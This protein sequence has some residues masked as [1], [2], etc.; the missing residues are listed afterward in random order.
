[1]HKWYIL[2][3]IFLALNYVGFFVHDTFAANAPGFETEL[4]AEWFVLPTAVVTTPDGRIF[5]AEKAG[6]IHVIK[7]GAVLPTPLLTL[8]DVNN[9]GDRWLIGFTLDPNFSSNGYIYVGYTYENT[10]GIQVAWSKTSRVVRYTVSG[11]T[12]IAGSKLVILG[13]VG[14]TVGTPSCNDYPV[15]SDCIP[16]DAISHSVGALHF[17][18]DGKLYI[19]TGDG[20]SFDYAD[21]LS[22]RAQ[23]LD[24]LAGKVLRI[25][26]DGT[27]PADNPFFT[28]D[29]NANRSKIWAYGV[30]NMF[31]FNFKPG[32]NQIFWGDVGWSSWEEVNLITP[33]ANLGWP[34]NEWNGP[35]PL[36]LGCTAT[37]AVNPLYTYPHD[38]NGAGSVVG[39]VFFS[40]SYPA[41][42]ANSY[43]YGDYAQNSF[44]KMNLTAGNSIIS[45][46][47]LIDNPEGPVDITLGN[48]GKIYF[49]SIYTGNLYRLNYTL[50]NR[51]PNA[52]I[53]ANPTAGSIP[54]VV[55]FSAS[56]SSDPDND[57]LSYTWN[58]PGG[59]TASGMNTTFTFATGWVYSV[60]VTV[61]DGNGWTNT[62]S[63]DITAGNQKPTATI[64]APANGYRYTLWEPIQFQWSGIDPETWAIPSG[65]IR[66]D[67]ILHHNVHLHFLDVLT[68]SV[69]N[70]SPPDHNDT[71]VYVEVQMTVTDPAGLTDTKSINLYLNNAGSATGNLILNPSLETVTAVADNPD[72][73]IKGW[74]GNLDPVFSYPI[75]GIHG[76]KAARV[77]V[78]SYTEWDAKWS[79]SPVSVTAGKTY[80]FQNQYR[81]NVQTEFYVA[82][83]YANGTYTYAPFYA[84]PSPTMWAFLSG[85][86]T[87]PEGWINASLTHT[88]GRIG[89]LETDNYYLGESIPDNY[90]PPIGKDNSITVN[91]WTSLITL[92]NILA[93]DLVFGSGNSLLP[94][95]ID[96]NSLISEPQ[97]IKV[98]PE[99]TWTANTTNGDV[100]FA[101]IS[102]FSGT[103]TIPYSAKDQRGNST[104]ANLIVT[105]N[106]N[107]PPPTPTNLITN[108]GVEL[109]AGTTPTGWNTGWYGNNNRV[110]TY[111]STWALSGQRSIKVDITSYTDGDGKW[112]FNDIPVTSGTTYNYSQQY[113]STA[114]TYLYARFQLPGNTYQYQFLKTVPAN[115]TIIPLTLTASVIAP[116]NATSMT[117]W[118]ALSS[119]GSLTLDTFSL[120]T[121]GTNTGTAPD[122][123]PPEVTFVSPLSG[124][125]LSGNVNLTANTSDDRW[126]FSVHFMLANGTHISPDST[127]S[128][129]TYSWDTR[130]VANGTYIVY[131]HAFDTA[132]NQKMTPI[133][134]FINNTIVPPP[135]PTNLITNSG[136]EL[137][138]GTT[139]TGWNTGWYGNNN[140][141]FTYLSTWALSGQRSIKV[142]ITSYTDGDGK[143]FF[144]DIP[145]T[146]GTTYNYSQQYIS[147]AP[148]Y[149]Y[150]RFQLP[151][152]TYQYQ[153][154]KTV[155]ANNTIIPLTLTAS[156]IAPANATSMTIWNA[157][158]SI[159]SLTLD[160]FSLSTPGTNTGTAPDTVPPTVTLSTPIELGI[161][162]GSINVGATANDNIGVA[163]VEFF[164]D[165]QSI[166]TDTSTPYSINLNT[167]VYSG[168]VHS[169]TARARDTNNNTTTTGERY[170]FTNNK[171]SPP[172]TVI[173]SEW[174]ESGT[175]SGG[176]NTPNQN[177]AITP[178]TCRFGPDTN[179]KALR[180]T[181]NTYPD[182]VGLERSVSV[183]GYTGITLSFCYKWDS[184]EWTDGIDVEYTLDNGTSWRSAKTINNAGIVHMFY[185]ADDSKIAVPNSGSLIPTPV[186]LS[187]S[188]LAQY[189]IELPPDVGGN[190]F[191]KLRIR[192]HMTDGDDYVW[193]DDI[194]IM[195]TPVATAD[196]TPPTVTMA[197]PLSGSTLSGTIT[198]RATAT[199]N[200]GVAWVQF[201]LDGVN[202]GAEDTTSPYQI[203]YN[204]TLTGNGSHTF[205][206]IARDAAWNTRTSSWVV[207]I[208]TNPTTG[209]WVELVTNGGLELGTLTTPTG[210]YTG[211]YGT[212]N[213]L[214]S[215][216][217]TGALTGQKS[218][219]VDI[220]SYTSGDGKWIFNDVP[221]TVG[222]T[223]I[224]SQKY[225]STVPSSLLVRYK[226]A[227][228]TY[229]YVYLKYLP[230]AA[231]ATTTTAEFTVPANITAATVWMSLDTIWSTI[232]DDVSLKQK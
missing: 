81:S 128:P 147:T 38:S 56:G 174:F 72:D 100:T 32:T 11:D 110:F 116:A 33:G 61:N 134:V 220:T 124:S 69:V 152:N 101:P 43:V 39:G 44:I 36:G 62:K 173:F 83:W 232:I 157:L 70:F 111:L 191:F 64:I 21:P 108:S 202:I 31:R 109:S 222:N 224:Y 92:P 198:V 120:S 34:C 37:W 227:N 183:V 203:S 58:F 118:N 189:Y 175:F 158:S 122:T 130:T 60:S 127:I 138:A 210:W 215:Y 160:T 95:S 144:N 24:S 230:T 79:P 19:S 141:V 195:G 228:N 114:P 216:I 84:P 121:P 50:W 48:D 184:L 15:T 119:I 20:A 167:L 180:V 205:R 123:T 4:I 187:Q 85:S 231:V 153:F 41:E 207:V 146:S 9:F 53:S 71:D 135:T 12:V 45:Q 57:I 226:L 159:G 96:L 99:G 74:W 133:T 137:S 107:V 168:W 204:S 3:L 82:V 17:G 154:L 194:K 214:F 172:T 151:G 91:Y 164:I 223:Y 89:W 54:L 192:D 27:A 212:N 170:I 136:V 77:D 103:T 218:V 193:I 67:F 126:A 142:D 199:D 225:A 171:K 98:N 200:I 1:M 176:W 102:G 161:Y 94:A 201:Q 26:P 206:A 209:T 23:N 66:W 197:Q 47:N 87:I 93:N 166:W 78:L 190:S 7:N 106:S 8:T 150:A 149:L 182:G 221:V 49:L 140:R 76:E 139:P 86:Y 129:Y 46:E 88:V 42:F 186:S 165:G 211:G 97:S 63:I 188:G 5:V 213:R 196:T 181:G 6:V 2:G 179:T 117:I 65:S 156:V 163:S 178:G 75:T 219:K 132:G 105:I 162:S 28:G 73:W 169:L 131:A 104:S 68:G 40:N 113:I 148:T 80:N 155:P 59:S 125:T 10:P 51:Q 25:N 208:I 145:V 112:F 14:G 30:R 16:S 13:S 217:S 90:I 143:W 177:Y 35:T 115:N 29:A 185:T 55:N 18:P 52:V 229:Q 22:L